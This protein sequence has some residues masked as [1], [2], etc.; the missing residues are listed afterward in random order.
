MFA[1]DLLKLIVETLL[2]FFS[3]FLF[4]AILG[5]IGVGGE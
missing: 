4:D 2:D 5:A 3:K 1:N